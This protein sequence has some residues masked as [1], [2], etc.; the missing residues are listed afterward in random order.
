MELK[1]I[2]SA[3]GKISVERAQSTRHL[4]ILYSNF[5]DVISNNPLDNQ[6]QF[7]QT[8]TVCVQCKLML[9]FPIYSVEIYVV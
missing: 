9:L 4:F 1:F 6:L 8:K 7:S 3:I 2:F 5:I